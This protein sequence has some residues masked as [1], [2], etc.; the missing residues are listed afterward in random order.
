MVNLN[1]VFANKYSKPRNYDVD[2]EIM[3]I[4]ENFQI[5]FDLSF[6]QNS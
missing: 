6:S 2:Q 5:V 4:N 1:G 3:V